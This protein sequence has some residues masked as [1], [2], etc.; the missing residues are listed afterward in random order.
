M[1]VL[2]WLRLPYWATGIG[3]FFLCAYLAGYLPLF[4]GLSRVAVHRWRL[5][6]PFVA[7]FVWMGFEYM[8][9]WFLT[10]FSMACLAT[11]STDFTN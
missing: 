5:P 6:L 8:R 1:L 4:I 10:G 3:G 11:L 2:H 9:Q 7:A